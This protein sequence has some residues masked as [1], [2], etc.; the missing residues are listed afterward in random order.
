MAG[1]SDFERT[2][3]NSLLG[4]KSRPVASGTVL[5]V[6]PEAPR[7]DDVYAVS[8]VPA[9]RKN[10]VP[11]IQPYRVLDS[12]SPLSAVYERVQT[13]ELLLVDLTDFVPD[14]LYVLGLAHAMGRSPLLMMQSHTPTPPFDLQ[15]LPRFDYS[16]DAE[17]LRDLREELTRAIRIQLAGIRA[18]P[19]DDV[20]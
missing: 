18:T 16:P 2:R 6:S 15:A 13:T 5:Y 17:G 4:L 7:F 9:L 3:I 20:T 14:V 19:F 11:T 12:E 1:P 10:N 8:V